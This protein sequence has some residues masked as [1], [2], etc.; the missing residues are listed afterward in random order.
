MIKTAAIILG[1]GSTLMFAQNATVEK[2][3]PTAQATVKLSDKEVEDLV[4]RSY[5]YV[6]MY[7]VIS[8]YALNEKNPQ[9]T[10]G[11]NKKFVASTLADHTMQVI[12]RPNNDTLYLPILADFRDDAVVIE[13]P[14]FDSKYVVL[15]T[16]AY[17]HY[18][19]IPLST[20]NGDFKKPTTMLF[21]TDHTK[22]YKGEKI[23]GIDKTLKMSGDFAAIFLRVM[24]HANEPERMKK[25]IEAM[26]SVKVMTLSEYL[27]KAKK[28]VTP[29]SFPVYSNPQGVYK[30]N[31]SEVMQFVVNHTIFSP[32]NEMDKKLLEVLKPLGIEPGKT[33]DAAKYPKIDADRLAKEEALIAKAALKQWNAPAGSPLADKIF[34]QKEKMSLEPM[35]L[36]SAVGPVGL[37]ASE[38]QYP[39]ISSKDGKPLMSDKHYVIKM[40]KEQLPPVKAFWS[41]TLY[42][43]KNGYFIPNEK[44]KYSVG[45]NSGMKLDEKG[46]IDIHIAAKKPEN[47]PVENWLPSGNKV[48][49]LDLILRMYGPD[50]EKMKGWKVPKAELVK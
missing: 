23:K 11:W 8:H 33:Y 34:L 17:D 24:P 44:K 45:E 35:V 50:K 28:A 5:Q 6:A 48:E 3:V 37:P 39:G 1:L 12:A 42:D 9:Y 19:D 29:V 21:Y 13:F 32:D 49:E 2:A 41:V 14:V 20:A 4:K 38:A 7:N 22:G 15:E 10:G 25:N 40:T 16:S 26:K 43:A 27:G 47:V 18:V 31:F 36:Q 46:G 30:N